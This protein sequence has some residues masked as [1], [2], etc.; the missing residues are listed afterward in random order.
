[1]T[2]MFKK[3]EKT[4]KFCGLY[5][6]KV[7]PGTQEVAWTGHLALLERRFPRRLA[8]QTRK[9]CEID[10]Q[11]PPWSRKCRWLLLTANQPGWGKSIGPTDSLSW[12]A[13]AA[14]QPAR[15]QSKKVTGHSDF[16]TAGASHPGQSR[17]NRLS[18]CNWQLFSI[19][20]KSKSLKT[21]ASPRSSIG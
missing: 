14:A 3:M 13:R 17:A 1:M 21:A 4:G 11:N 2:E 5:G 20:V 9:L 16:V 10:G 8:N 12:A 15:P 18:I 7:T 19:S 6:A